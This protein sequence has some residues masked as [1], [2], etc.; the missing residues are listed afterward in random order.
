M[1]K[2]NLEKLSLAELK[3][4]QKDVQAAIASFEKRRKAEAKMALEAVAKE[5]GMTLAEILGNGGRAKGAGTAPKYQ[6][7]S[8]PSQTWSGRGRQPAWYKAALAAGKTAE[9]LAI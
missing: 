1:A 3:T 2:L 9:S 4:L 7:P 5:H 6:N 8:D